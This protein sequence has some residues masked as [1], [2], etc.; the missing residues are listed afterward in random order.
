MH[1]LISQIWIIQDCCLFKET[2]C[3]L[4][5]ACLDPA[6]IEGSWCRQWLKVE[7]CLCCWCLMGSGWPRSSAGTVE[8]WV[9]RPSVFFISYPSDS[10]ADCSHSFSDSLS[11]GQ[12]L[13]V[14][15]IGSHV[16]ARTY[17]VSLLVSHLMCVSALMLSPQ[18]LFPPRSTLNSSLYC[19]AESLLMSTIQYNQIKKTLSSDILTFSNF[20]LSK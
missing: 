13:I 12:M 20:H 16:N 17:P 2:L 3:G 6:S 1:N 7:A 5:A 14:F 15:I 9:S 4:D 18:C 8:A 19:R 11:A 10:M